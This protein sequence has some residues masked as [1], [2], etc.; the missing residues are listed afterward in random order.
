[1]LIVETYPPP[2]GV[3]QTRVPVSLMTGFEE[4]VWGNVLPTR[5]EQEK[6]LHDAGRRDQSSAA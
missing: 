1:M 4:M 3:A 5:E 6:L 2:R